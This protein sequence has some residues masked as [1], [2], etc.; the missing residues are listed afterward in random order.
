MSELEAVLTQSTE[1]SPFAQ[2]TNDLS[3]T[4]R[5]VVQDYFAHLQAVMLDCLRDAGIALDVHRTSARW[6]AQVGMT[7][8]DIAI[9]EVSPDRLRGYGPVDP[10]A[11]TQVATLQQALRRLVQRVAAYLRQGL[12]HDLSQRLALLEASRADV[13]RSPCWSGSSPA[14]G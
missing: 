1:P 5:K 13:G 11:A 2:H 12:G 7:G 6:A 8:I 4:E 3:P 14:G 10:A 9:A